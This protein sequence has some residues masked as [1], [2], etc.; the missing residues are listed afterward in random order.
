MTQLHTRADVELALERG[1]LA[2]WKERRYRAFHR[3]M[4]DD[5]APFPCHFAA[6]AHEDG[7]VR[8]L[9]APSEDT[10]EGKAAL[11]DGLATY[12]DGARDIAGLTSMAVF[13]EPPSEDLSVEA[14][15]D[16]F[17]GLLEH[18]HRHDPEPW[19]DGIPADPSDP[20]WAFCYAG[21]PVFAV[22]RAPC[23]ER[24]RSRHTPYGLEITVQPRW[25]FDGLGGDTE[26]GQRA[27]RLIRERLAAYDDVPR[28]PD[29]GDYGAPG[30]HE[31]EQYVLPD[32]NEERPSGFPIDDWTVRRKAA[33]DTE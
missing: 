23:Y 3:T 16:R 27:R 13:F 25:V 4:T 9:F 8:Y 30:V 31:W 29:I 18:L 21:E 1:G 5:D 11:A 15:R 24:R 17:W 2:A 6:D 22:A 28:H 32:D 26:E 10:D 20:E 19:P 7:N 14:Y 33:D 12:L